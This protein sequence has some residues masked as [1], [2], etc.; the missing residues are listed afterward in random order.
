M[1]LEANSVTA[2]LNGRRIIEEVTFEARSGEIIGLIGPNGSGK[3]T[4]LRTVYRMLRPLAG[5]ILLDSDDVWKLSARESAQRTGIVVQE[6]NDN[7]EFTVREVVEMGRIPHKKLWEKDNEDDADTVTRSLQRVAMQDLIDRAYNTLSGGEKQRILIARALAQEPRL[8][9]MDEPTNHLDIRFQLEIME[10]MRKIGVTTLV[11]LHD[12]NL[13]AA[14]CTRLYLLSNGR[15]VAAGKPEEVLTPPILR[16][17]FGVEAVV[18]KHPLK[19]CL[20][21]AFTALATSEIRL[22]DVNS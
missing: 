9:V 15:I 4:T 5:N 10:L 20:C 17:V 22:A 2:V 12:L 19:E 21:L 18:S 1:K 11:T 6:P 14:F 13:A 8:L 7:F 16:Q 3:S